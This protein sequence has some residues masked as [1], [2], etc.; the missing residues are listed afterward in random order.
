MQLVQA[1]CGCVGLLNSNNFTPTTF[2]CK[3]HKIGFKYVFALQI[4]KARTT[5]P[6][7]SIKPHVEE[8][9][10]RYGNINQA[11]NHSS[12]TPATIKRILND[13]YKTV[14]LKTARKIMDALISKRE[15]DRKNYSVN[16]NLI[17]VKHEQAKREAKMDLTGY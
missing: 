7:R 13:H 12:L 6:A 9:V 1:Q 16:G 5:V 4:R 8:L 15:N 17:K 14:Q 11:A 3:R 2:N 10:L